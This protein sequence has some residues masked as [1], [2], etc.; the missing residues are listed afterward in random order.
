[1]RSLYDEC[2]EDYECGNDAYCWYPD[3]VYRQENKK[4]CLSL[5]SQ[6]VGHVFGWGEIYDALETRYT[7]ERGACFVKDPFKAGVKDADYIDKPD[8]KEQQ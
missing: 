1:M 5:Y 4:I 8:I 6:D 7:K 2:L 3:G